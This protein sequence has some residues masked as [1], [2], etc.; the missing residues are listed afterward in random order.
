MGCCLANM[1][2]NNVFLIQVSTLEP[3]NVKLEDTYII[4]ALS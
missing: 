2:H 4:Q 3:V 1:P